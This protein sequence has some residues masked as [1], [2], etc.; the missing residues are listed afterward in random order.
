MTVC[1]VWSVSCLLFF[2]CSHVPMDGHGRTADRS[3]SKFHQMVLSVVLSR[4]PK[5]NRKP[6]FFCQN[7]GELTKVFWGQVKMVLPS[8]FCIYIV[9]NSMNKQTNRR[10]NTHFKYVHRDH[11][12]HTVLTSDVAA[13]CGLCQEKWT[14]ALKCDLTFTFTFS[15]GWMTPS[16]MSSPSAETTARV[17]CATPN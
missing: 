11:R 6:R 14:D 5:L 17:Q 16:K 13:T 8:D 1:T 10:R 7:R 12:R 15:S 3:R 9:S 2:Y 4:L